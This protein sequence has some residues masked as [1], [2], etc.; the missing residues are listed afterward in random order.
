MDIGATLDVTASAVQQRFKPLDE[1]DVDE[2][3]RLRDRLAE[4]RE[5]LNETDRRAGR[6]ADS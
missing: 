3:G 1:I 6:K 5:A 4:I 2:I